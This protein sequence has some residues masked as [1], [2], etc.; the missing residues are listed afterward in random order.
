MFR[1]IWARCLCVRPVSSIAAEWQNIQAVEAWYRRPAPAGS[2]LTA[3]GLRLG[4]AA[5]HPEWYRRSMELFLGKAA[6]GRIKPVVHAAVPWD[7]FEVA[8]PMIRSRSAR[9]CLRG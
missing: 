8:E 6:E 4:M 1:G 2:G 7:S 5:L 9:E 3:R